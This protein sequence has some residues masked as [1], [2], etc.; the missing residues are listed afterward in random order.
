MRYPA[1]ETAEKHRRILGEASRLFRERG[2]I[3]VSVGEIMK[4]TGL[5]HGPFYNHFASKQDLVCESITAESDR[6]IAELLECPPTEE[7]RDA[8]IEGYLSTAHCEAPGMGCLMA[9]L[10]A[11]V[12]R[13]P[14]TK[15]AFTKHM[16]ALI[17]RFSSHFPWRRSSPA[18]SEAIHT[19]AAMVGGMVLA[20]ASDDPDLAEEI[21][22]EVRKHL[23]ERQSR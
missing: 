9:S 2:F 17:S 5:T 14:D 16:Q 22:G 12:A 15:P 21:L 18:R 20:R 11:E 23:Y 3:D 4:A 10:A 8:Y 19:L 6:A 1:H 7:A 13:E